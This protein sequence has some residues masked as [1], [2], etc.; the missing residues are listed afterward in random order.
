MARSSGGRAWRAIM[1][2]ECRRAGAGD[3]G[4]SAIAFGVHLELVKEEI[5][6]LSCTTSPG[7]QG[8]TYDHSLLPG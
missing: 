5:H 3:V 2:P 6:K 1:S 8:L 4:E 7:S